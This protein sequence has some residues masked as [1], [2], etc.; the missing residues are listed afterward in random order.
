MYGRD[1]LITIMNSENKS[2]GHNSKQNA[3]LVNKITLHY[4][5]MSKK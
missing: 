5:D 2:E 4:M 1:M 3:K